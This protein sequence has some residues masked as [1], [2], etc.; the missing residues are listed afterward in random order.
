M[1]LG[2]SRD[3]WQGIIA[4]TSELHKGRG[5]PHTGLGEQRCSHIHLF[6]NNSD[7]NADYQT[8]TYYRHLL[9]LVI[10]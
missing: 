7:N 9:L 4:S 3:V 10:N 2:I 6:L 1:A 8:D 5:K